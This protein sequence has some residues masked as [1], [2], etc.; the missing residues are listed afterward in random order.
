MS[1]RVGRSYNALGSL[2]V[3]GR[4]H[5]YIVRGH[6]LTESVMTS[7]IVQVHAECLSGFSV[8]RARDVDIDSDCKLRAVRRSQLYH[9]FSGSKDPILFQNTQLE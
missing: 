9:T 2:E 6:M 7:H 4:T 1:I 3:W 5:L 8:C